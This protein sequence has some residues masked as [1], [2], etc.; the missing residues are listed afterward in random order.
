MKKTFILKRPSTLVIL[1]DPE[2][3]KI[4]KQYESIKEAS[5]VLGINYRQL[6]RLF[7]EN[8]QQILK[9]PLD[10]QEKYNIIIG[11]WE[12]KVYKEEL[13]LEQ[14]VEQE[15]SKEI[16][17]KNKEENVYRKNEILYELE[18]DGIEKEEVNEQIKIETNNKVGVYMIENKINNKRFIGLVKKAGKDGGNLYKAFRQAMYSNAQRLKLLKIDR[19]KYGVSNFKFYVL[20]FTTEEEA[21]NVRRKFISCISPE[22]NG[23]QWKKEKAPI[24]FVQ[25]YPFIKPNIRGDKRIGPHS[26]KI[27]SI[28]YG[29]LLGDSFAEKRIESGG[30]RISFQQEDTNM[31]YLMKFHKDISEMGYCSKNKPEI[32]TRIGKG[33]KIRRYYKFH[34]WTFNSFNRI[35][36]SWYDNKNIKRVPQDIALYLTPRALAYWIMDD[37]SKLSNGVKLSTNSFT[38]KD[39][40]L[41]CQV[42]KDKYNLVC[43]IQSAGVEDQYVIYIWKESMDNLTKIVR[44]YMVESMLRKLHIK[45]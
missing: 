21:I 39:L 44:P 45:K 43:S 32:L 33:G 14:D 30:T 6:R 16:L 17:D 42:L 34:T 23:E 11:L 5:L 18:Y 37:G 28:I 2:T 20:E 10:I 27:I 31:E 7:K 3:K 36:E 41:L 22:Y 19:E 1:K 38:L 25:D 40:D 26:E 13:E 12:K 35:R 29:T 8:N 15:D 24:N 9:V 4:L